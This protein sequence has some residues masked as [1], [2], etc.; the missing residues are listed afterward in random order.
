MI[1]VQGL[2][3]WTGTSRPLYL[4]LG[5]FDGVHRGH[6]LIINRTVELARHK[7][8][9]SAVLVFNP[10]P[11]ALFKPESPFPML[12]D[13][14]GKAEIISALGVDYFI[15]QQ[16]NLQ[17]ASIPPEL[18][19]NNYLWEILK[20]SGV[21]VGEDYSFGRKRQGTPL[22]MLELGKR[23]GLEVEVCPLREH[24][25]YPV[26]S[27]EIRKLIGSGEVLKASG[28]LNYYFC[29]SGEVIAGAGRGNRLLYPTA[30]LKVSSDLIWP[31]QGVYLSAIEGAAEEVCFGVSNV[32]GTPT[33]RQEMM[34]VETHILNFSGNLYHKKIRVYFLE[35]LREVTVFAT[36]GDLKEQIA[37]DISKANQMAVARYHPFRSGFLEAVGSA[38]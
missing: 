29:R 21:V 11:Q 23:H 18:F 1:W 5:N 36:P 22:T 37:R 8:G 16:F 10:H 35:K 15:V 12:T 26:S 3:Q 9:L 19:V 7:G 34:S 33:F 4:A 25:G 31:G 27:S 13:L 6:Q 17:L 2:E 14:P 28:L 24:D 38:L 20:A 30:N 32:G